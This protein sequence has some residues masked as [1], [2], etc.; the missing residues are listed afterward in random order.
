[1]LDDKAKKLVRTIPLSN[2]TISRRI[3]DLT[4]DVKATLLSRIKSTKFS[5]QIDESTDVAGLAILIAFVRYQ[6]ESFQEDLL[7]YKPLT[8]NT[9]GAKIVKL[10]ESVFTENSIPWDN[11][12]DV[13]TYGA[14]AMTGRIKEGVISRIKEKAKEC[15][16][17]HC[18]LQRHSHAVKKCRLP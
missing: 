10:I 1:M 13:C 15:S 14:K 11:S 6:H 17:S 9:T 12:V 4:E 8:I 7:F 2:N 3:G 16:S 5:L 18:I